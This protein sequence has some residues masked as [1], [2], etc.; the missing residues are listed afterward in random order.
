[1]KWY[2]HKH[3]Q[4]HIT[5]IKVKRGDDMELYYPYVLQI[6]N[7]FPRDGVAIGALNLQDLVQFGYIGLI[8][9]WNKLD[10]DRDQPEKWS[11]IKKR[12]K[13]AIR[14]GIDKNGSFI[15]RPINK[16]EVDRNNLLAADKTLVD[17][18]PKFFMELEPGAWDN[19]SWD[20]LRLADIIDDYLYDNF[21]N[22][23]HINIL[24]ACF[25][26]DMP[27]RMTYKELAKKYRM[28]EIGIRKVKERMI[29]KLRD[30]ENFT[31]I[32]ENLVS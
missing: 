28:S 31:K 3:H 2:L 21:N 1:M 20:N 17:A 25:G 26:M 12:I 16:L 29:S 13:W 10:H 4:M 5:D 32:I 19:Y 7:T 23:D 24:K 30:D 14:R 6:A 11:Y 9:A 8:D 27:K 15:A 22:A 18:F